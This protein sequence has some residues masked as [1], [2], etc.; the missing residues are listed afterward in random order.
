MSLVERLIQELGPWSWWVFGL[1]L[2]G[3]EV[4]APGTFFLWFGIAAIL[5]GSV[6]LFVDLSWQ[7]EL[8]LF[9]LLSLASVFAGRSLLRK[10]S[11]D[12]GDPSLNRRGSR[13]VGRVFVL[14]E[15]IVQ[16]IGRL[17]VDDTVWRIAGPDC[18]GGTRI[19]VNAVQGAQLI[20]EPATD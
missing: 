11:A 18:P 8:I 20:V 1:L 16:G 10:E 17:K 9:L 14:D 12:E 7:L 15:P 5:V 2:L 6:A 19:R 13:Y 4:L 3:L